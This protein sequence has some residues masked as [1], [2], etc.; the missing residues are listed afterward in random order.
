[1]KRVGQ[2]ILSLLLTCAMLLSLLPSIA[3]ADEPEEGTSP[4]SK[5]IY[6]SATGGE[7]EL[8]SKGNPYTSLN[9]AVDAINQDADNQYYTVYLMSDVDAAACA[10]IADHHVTIASL[11]AEE[12]QAQE[13]YTITRGEDFQPIQDNARSTYNPAMIEVTV[14][15]GKGA[16][17]TL[18][19]V[20]LDDAGLHEGTIFAQANSSGDTSQNSVRVQDAMIAAYGT[21]AAQAEIV[22]GSGATLKNFGGMSAV[23]VTA[24]AA[25]TMEEGSVICDDTVNDRSKGASGS[26]GPAGAVWVQGTGITMNDGAVIRDIVGRA[27]YVDGGSA[28]IGGNVVNIKADADMWQ[29]TAGIAVHGRGDSDITLAATCEIRD[30]D[31]NASGGSVIGMYASDLDM[32]NGAKITNITGTMALYMDD[33]NSNYQHTALVNGTVEQVEN[34]PVMRSW[35]GHIEIGS[36]GIVQDSGASGGQVLYTNNG[37][38]YTIRGKV[39]NNK[40]TALYIANQSGGRP[41]ATMEEGAEIS[42][43]SGVAVRVNNGSLFTMNGG[44]ISDNTTGVQ[45]S[46]K[47]DFKGVEFVM[48]GGA[49]SGNTTGI[50]YTVNGESKVRLNGGTLSDNGSAYQ[51]FASG[52]S[53]TGGS[54]SDGSEN[55]YIASGVLQ[56]NTTVYTSFGTLTLDETYPSLWLGR[57]SSDA[58]NHI[59]ALVKAGEGQ[60][61][62]AV[63]GSYA[64]WLK[65][66]S[67]TL[68]FTMSR[69]YTI[70]KGVGLHVGYIPLKEDGTPADGAALTLLPLVNSETL[71]VTLT[72]LTPGTPYALAF[73]AEDKYYVTIDPADITVYMGGEQG[74]DHVTEDGTITSS[75][76][77]PEFGFRIEAKKGLDPTDILFEEEGTGKVWKVVPYNDTAADIYRIVPAVE[78]QDPVRLVFTDDAGNATVSDEFT[79]GLEVNKHFNMGI[80]AGGVDH[81]KI[82][83]VQQ[84]DASGETYGIILNT[85]VLSVRGT[86]SQVEYAA[87]NETVTNGKPGVTADDGVTFTINDSNVSVTDSTGIALLFDDIIESTSSES[88]RTQLLEERADQV[89]NKPVPEDMIRNYE[90]KYLDLVDRHNGNTWVKASSDVTVSWPYPAGTNKDTGFTLLHFEDLHR[91]MASNEIAEDIAGCTV[92]E[93][94]ILEKTDTH[95]VFKIGSGGFSPFALIWEESNI[96]SVTRYTITAKADEGGSISPS[97]SVRVSRGGSKTFTMKAND[98]YEIDD[99][100]VDGE[101]VGAVDRYTFQN[102]KAA[103]TISV[104]FRQLP[105]TPD[106]TGVS[107]WLNTKDHFAYLQGFP[108][109]CFGP[110]QNMTRAEAAQMF[111]NLL[112]DKDVTQTVFFSDVPADAWYADAV[113]TLAS[114]GILEG[115]GGD[116][117]EP[118]RVITRAEF[119]AMGMRFG[120][121]S[122]EGKNIFSDVDEDDWFYD[123]VVGSIQYGWINGFTDGTFRPYQTI[124]RAEV[125]V[126]TNR[127]LGRSAD[128]DYVDEHSDQLRKFCDVS[129]DNWAYYDIAEATNAHEYVKSGGQETWEK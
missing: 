39:L 52:G 4:T 120:D 37:S 22:L 103:H 51:I 34:N 32:Q 90:L 17:V 65:A 25:L 47:D 95:I 118:A 19:N 127:M 107:D 10:R 123:V 29:G 114:I 56:G 81:G 7:G 63:K 121:L 13:I 102:V 3:L 128:E 106:D 60:D 18:E 73:V 21:D 122:T 79:V 78:G 57:A 12:G 20:T 24:G 110:S 129:K 44:T 42:G 91:D 105:P 58:K 119:T 50:S 84:G 113:N 100:L 61:N 49:I 43:T 64:L 96:P 36:T 27:F 28:T 59:D 62:W 93:V 125:T 1:M 6:V 45:V 116:R 26:T 92:S 54:D 108:N 80:Y 5:T 16:S 48:N 35:Y 31:T 23:R 101:S 86:T 87:L 89:L 14:P 74:S 75:T 11:P 109:S 76:S 46:G 83:A 67:D 82:Y 77:L 41:E 40:G 124:T 15:A 2:H 30:F 38:R 55:I 9:A 33:V 112:L 98:G 104:S 94:S 85:G 68:H 111:Y 126:I 66:D 117:F 53:A 72:G 8:G 99:V 70:E 88:N 97:G 71:D 69:P 115:V